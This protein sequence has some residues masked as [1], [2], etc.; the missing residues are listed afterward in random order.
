MRTSGEIIDAFRDA[1][2]QSGMTPPDDILAD[3]RL[4]RFSPMTGKRSSSVSKSGYYVLHIDDAPAGSFGDWRTGVQTPWRFDKP[5]SKVDRAKA[6][7]AI[8]AAKKARLREEAAKHTKA[9][10]K[11][12]EIWRRSVVITSQ[13]VHPYLDRKRVRGN[14]ARI[15]PDGRVVVAVCDAGHNIYGLQFIDGE[16]EKKF[17]PGTAKRG[18]FFMLGDP[19]GGSFIGVAEGFATA[20]TI[21]EATGIPVAVAFD[22]GNLVPVAREVLRAYKQIIAV[23]ADDDFGTEG[24]PGL[25][26]A[27]KATLATRGVLVK[28]G[29]W[30]IGN[31]GTDFNDLRNALGGVGNAAIA[32]AFTHATSWRELCK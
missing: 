7:E 31:R 3:G 30:P 19:R 12:Q 1:M 14:G 21:H 5:M 6:R 32:F 13:H 9:A 26:A 15:A 4:H 29:P 23:F 25:A 20:A 8:A 24:N 22:A 28:P 16:G 27:E 11:A 2:C 17:L 10:E 18:R